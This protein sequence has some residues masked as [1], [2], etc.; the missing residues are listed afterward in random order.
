MSGREATGARPK[1]GPAQVSEEI[2]R[3]GEL[4]AKALRDLWPDWL[5]RAAPAR[6]HRRTLALALTYRIQCDVLGGLSKLALRAL[7]LVAAREFGEGHNRAS[8]PSRQIRAGTTL[9]REWHGVAH[10]V[11]VVEGGFSWNGAR[12]RSLSAIARA[13]TGTRWNGLVFF[14]LKSAGSSKP[15]PVVVAGQS[16]WAPDG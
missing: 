9:I 13:I 12:H 14:G 4:E 11:L 2:A 7:D 6:M 10:E 8:L 15:N 16:A 3:I 5:G 1:L